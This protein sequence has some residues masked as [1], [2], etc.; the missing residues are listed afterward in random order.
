ML[1]CA[2]ETAAR[3]DEEVAR[4]MKEYYDRAV[5]IIKEN[6]D[7]LEKIA[8]YLIEK[9]TITGKEFIRMYREIKGL[10]E[11]E[12]EKEEGSDKGD[13][14]KQETVVENIKIN[15]EDPVKKDTIIKE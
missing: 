13:E 4:R 9:E 1:N 14:I 10:P 2:D 12:D 5:N 8:E 6:R 15:T 3:I 7:A 11:P